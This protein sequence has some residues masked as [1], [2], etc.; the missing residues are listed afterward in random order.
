MRK[1][2][3]K[4][5]SSYDTDKENNCCESCFVGNCTGFKKYENSANHKQLITKRGITPTTTYTFRGKPNLPHLCFE[6]Q[7]AKNDAFLIISASKAQIGISRSI[8]P[9]D[10]T[11]YEGMLPGRKINLYY[12]PYYIYNIEKSLIPDAIAILPD[13]KKQIKRYRRQLS[14]KLYKDR[15]AGKFSNKPETKIITF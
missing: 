3:N 7:A 1:C 8:D 13:V 9:K 2:Y 11:T 12:L 4:N 14:R 6:A 15:L 10:L 5:C